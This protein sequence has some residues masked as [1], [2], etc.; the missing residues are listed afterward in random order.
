MV[1]TFRKNILKNLYGLS[2]TDL[3]EMP[4]KNKL[5]KRNYATIQNATINSPDSDH[6]DH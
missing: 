4:I 5:V 2:Y 1:T 6:Q 3:R